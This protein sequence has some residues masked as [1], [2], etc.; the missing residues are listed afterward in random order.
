MVGF[1]NF[2][3]AGDRQ[4]ATDFHRFGCRFKP[5]SISWRT[6]SLRVNPLL[7]A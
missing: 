7:D 2:F 4:Q 5:A 6:A 3:G 1:A